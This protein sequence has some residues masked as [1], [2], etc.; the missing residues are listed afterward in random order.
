MIAW[1]TGE[2]AVN[3]RKS[4]GSGDACRW[5]AEQ[6]SAGSQILGV[7]VTGASLNVAVAGSLVL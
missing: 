3:D 1:A 7:D 2:R 5:L 4:A 6:R